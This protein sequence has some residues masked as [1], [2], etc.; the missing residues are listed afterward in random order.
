MAEVDYIIQVL[1]DVRKSK[2]FSQRDVA[3]ALGRSSASLSYWERGLQSPSLN[4]LRR[5]AEMLDVNLRA[6]YLGADLSE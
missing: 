4:H 3:T 5:W 2:G 6:S 1:I